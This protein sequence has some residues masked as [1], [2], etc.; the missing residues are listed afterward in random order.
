ML[1]NSQLVCLPPVGILKPVMFIW[2][3]CFLQFEWHACELASVGV[4]KCMTTIN[5]IYFQLTFCLFWH[6]DIWHFDQKYTSI[7]QEEE[8]GTYLRGVFFKFWL[9]GSGH[10]QRGCLFERGS[11][12]HIFKNK[13]FHWWNFYSVK[14]QQYHNHRGTGKIL[15][16]AE[17]NLAKWNLLVTDAQDDFLVMSSFLSPIMRALAYKIVQIFSVNR[18]PWSER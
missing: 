17:Y 10:I 7:K 12:S 13:A 2:N 4:V 14:Q 8:G 5:N 9:V 18:K 11:N 16:G 6:F 15:L 3:I 1:V